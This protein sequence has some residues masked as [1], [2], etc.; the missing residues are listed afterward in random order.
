MQYMTAKEAAEKWNISQRRVAVLCAENRIENA[1]ML[2][3]MWL[4]P[5]DAQKP[6]DA[7]SLR[8]FENKKI[9]PFVKWAGGKGQI[10]EIIKENF[11]AGFGETIRK[12]AEPFVGGGAVLFEILANYDLDEIMIADIN[13]ELMNSFIVVRDNVDELINLL[14][15]MQ[16]EFLPLS[17]EERKIYYYNKRELFN[18]LKQDKSNSMNVA[19]AALFIFLNKTCFNG[20]YRVNS[21]GGFNVPMGAYKNPLICDAENLQLISQKLQNVRIVCGDYKESIDFIDENT[22]VYFDPPYRPLNATS[23]F[24]SYNEVVFT[25]CNQ[26]ELAEYINMLNERKAK[27]LL[28]NSDPK[29]HNEEDNFFDDLYANYNIKRIEASRMINSKSSGRGKIKEL[30]ISNF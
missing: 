18:T 19:L 4:I 5:K 9:K 29:N 6:Q 13:Q 16:K 1:E 30:L 14:E 24:T 11:P 25:D 8:Y 2:G 17:T 28:S 3:N 22:F 26:E 15:S 10:L 12:Y 21:K 27:I 20:L 7:R 23:A